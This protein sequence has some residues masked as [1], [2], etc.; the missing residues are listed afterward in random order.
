MLNFEV[1][2]E[3]L[4]IEGQGSELITKDV[5]MFSDGSI[6]VNNINGDFSLKGSNSKLANEGLIIEAR[7]IAKQQQEQQQEQ[8]QEPPKC[9]GVRTSRTA[10]CDTG[11]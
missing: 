10:R 2:I 4:K 11:N 5:K 6:E 8:E 1:K 3:K 9:P 7:A